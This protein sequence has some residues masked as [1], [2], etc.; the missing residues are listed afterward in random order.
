MQVYGLRD[1]RTGVIRYVGRTATT[2]KHALWLNRHTPSNPAVGEWIKELE[3]VGLGPET[4]LLDQSDD[5][6]ALRRVILQL[7]SEGVDLLN[8]RIPSWIRL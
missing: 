8:R 3:R 2:L 6:N 1:P 5:P 7:R 4:V